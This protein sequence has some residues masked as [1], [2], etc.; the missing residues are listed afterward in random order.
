M[1]RLAALAAVAAFAMSSTF[2]FAKNELV[3]LSEQDFFNKVSVSIEGNGNRLEILQE[4]PGHGAANII[5]AT[6]EGNNNGGPLDAAFAP[7]L[8]RTGLR[9]GT[10]SQSGFDNRMDIRISGSSNLFAFA[11]EGSGNRLTASM[12]G[13]SNQATVMQTGINNQASF[14]QSGI[15]NMINISQTSW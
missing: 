14:S 5:N 10:L 7:R 13:T 3:L 15:G 9:P 1:K 11:Q 2:A 6:I 12:M 4:H 8:Q